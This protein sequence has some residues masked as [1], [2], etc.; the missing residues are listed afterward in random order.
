MSS[1]TSISNEVS[2]K[3]SL[4]VIEEI[5]IED[6]IPMCHKC[7]FEFKPG[8]YICQN[9]KVNLCKYHYDDHSSNN[10]SHLFTH[11]HK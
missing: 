4:N 5:T 2:Q 9:C 11:L 10:T 8:E 3:N 6:Q 1:N 7:L